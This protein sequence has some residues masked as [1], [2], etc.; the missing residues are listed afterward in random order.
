[1]IMTVAI[2][3]NL[4]NIARA[5]SMLCMKSCCKYEGL[6]DRLTEMAEKPPLSAVKELFEEL[7][8]GVMGEPARQK[9]S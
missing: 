1:M 3:Y 8:E 7:G 5:V 2:V 4:V 9:S 6:L